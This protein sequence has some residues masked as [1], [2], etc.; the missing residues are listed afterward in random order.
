MKPTIPSLP[1]SKI[2]NE[3]DEKSWLEVRCMSSACRSGS[4][5]KGE[6]I[7]YLATTSEDDGVYKTPVVISRTHETKTIRTVPGLASLAIRLG[8]NFPEIPLCD[9]DT[10]IWKRVAGS[11]SPEQHTGA[12]EWRHLSP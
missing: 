7:L 4:V 3:L 8:I 5:I 10:G 12:T 2:A 6:W 1:I 9:G 11:S